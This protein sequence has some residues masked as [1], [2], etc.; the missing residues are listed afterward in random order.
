MLIR[1]VNRSAAKRILSSNAVSPVRLELSS[2]FLPYMTMVSIN[3]SFLRTRTPIQASAMLSSSREASVL[4][5]PRPS[6]VSYFAQVECPLVASVK[7]RLYNA[8]PQKPLCAAFCS[9]TCESIRAKATQLNSIPFDVAFTC[10]MHCHYCID[11]NIAYKTRSNDCSVKVR[12]ATNSTSS[13][14]LGE[15]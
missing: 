13:G 2:K 14:S 3:S 7:M 10:F 11:T 4:A 8:G 15:P 5:T 1:L 12:L 9:L 6:L